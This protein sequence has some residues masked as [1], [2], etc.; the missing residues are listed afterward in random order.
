MFPLTWILTH[1]IDETSPLKNYDAA[2]LKEQD[3][4]L[5]L[6]VEA[7]DVS[8]AAQIIDTKGYASAQI[9]LGMRYVDVL[10]VDAAGNAVA[11]LSSVS[12]IERDTGPEP[13]LSGWA[14]PSWDD[15]DS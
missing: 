1:R 11:D 3:A 5:W 6:G 7:R 10:S 13:P 15:A 4:R 8:L 12:R 14:D 2:R 9:A